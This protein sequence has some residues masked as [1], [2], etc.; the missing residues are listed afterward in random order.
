MVILAVDHRETK[1]NRLQSRRFRCLVDVRVDICSV[2]DLGQAVERR[3]VQ[4]VLEKDRLKAAPAV[5]VT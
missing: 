3:V 2:H 4:L 1:C 5:D